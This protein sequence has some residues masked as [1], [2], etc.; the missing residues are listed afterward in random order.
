MLVYQRVQFRWFSTNSPQMRSTNF[1]WVVSPGPRIIWIISVW[2][3]NLTPTRRTL[4]VVAQQKCLCKLGGVFISHIASMYCYI[5]IY[6]VVVSN[7]FYFHPQNLGNDP[8][9]LSHIF[10]LGARNHQLAIFLIPSFGWIFSLVFHVG[11]PDPL[12]PKGMK[13]KSSKDSGTNR[14]SPTEQ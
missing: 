13:T 9:W 5:V 12:I 6:W 1:C 8:I 14:W 7:V 10:Q 11:I 2:A 3:V 4:R